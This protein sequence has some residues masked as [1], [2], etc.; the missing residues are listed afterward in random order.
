MTATA[1][2]LPPA[3]TKHFPQPPWQPMYRAF[4]GVVKGTEKRFAVATLLKRNDDRD[5]AAAMEAE[6]FESQQFELASA[7]TQSATSI[8]PAAHLLPAKRHARMTESDAMLTKASSC[9]WGVDECRPKQL[10]AATKL[11]YDPT[12]LG[13]LLVVDR[14]GGDKSHI[15]QL[16]ATMVNGIILVPVIYSGAVKFPD[17]RKFEFV[18][19][20]VT[21]V[22]NCDD[23]LDI[24]AKDKDWLRVVFGKEKVPKF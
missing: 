10:E 13:K 9:A 11:L 1:G 14:T 23:V 3:A 6:R 16:V 15:L 2:A 21:T 7:L 12:S 8:A 24:L 22:G 17:S 20:Y 18:Y 4:R 5:S 19:T